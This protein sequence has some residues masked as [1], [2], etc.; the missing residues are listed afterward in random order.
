LAQRQGPDGRELHR[1]QFDVEGFAKRHDLHA[2]QGQIY[3]ALRAFI[4]A[5]KQNSCLQA[6][7]TLQ[8]WETGNVSVLGLKRGHNVL[9]LFNFSGQTQTIVPKSGMTHGTD[10]ISGKPLELQGLQLPAYSAVWLTQ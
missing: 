6:N 3:A 2:T 10:L 4:K 8:V 7:L 9:G 5:K 1:P